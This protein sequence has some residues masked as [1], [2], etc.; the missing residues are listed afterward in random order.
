MGPWQTVLTAIGG[1]G[2]LYVL[3][4]FLVKSIV[5]HRLTKDL[6]DHRATLTRSSDDHRATLTRNSDDHR[7][8]LQSDSEKAMTQLRHELQTTAME[9]EVRYR[10]M[11]ERVVEVLA[12]TY[13]HLMRSYNAVGSLIREW[14]VEGAAS[15]LEKLKA[16][17]TAAREFREYFS[18]NQVFLPK[19][20]AEEIIVMDRKLMDIAWDYAELLNPEFNKMNREGRDPW[21]QCLSD[22]RN[23]ATPLLDKLADR[24]RRELGLDSDA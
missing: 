15:K 11:R 4:K 3:L 19:K 18:P 10:Q 7:A 1:M 24:F 9:H 6:D 8:T 20:L 16:A 23:S 12:E 21:S 13:R 14:E 22:F 5:N 17:E 2:G